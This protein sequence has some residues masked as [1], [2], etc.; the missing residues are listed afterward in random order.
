[1][2]SLRNATQRRNHRE[3]AQPENREK[4]GLLEKHKDYSLRAKDYNE[5]KKR[6]QI[7]RQ[8]ATERNPDEFHYGMLSSRSRDGK[9]IVDRGNPVLSQDAVKLLK[10]QDS[11]YLRTM[12]QRTRRAVE[13]LEQEFVIKEGEG[14]K[15]L[16][17]EVG[18]G[19][20]QHV[21]FVGSRE[22]QSRL[23]PGK[24]LDL[25]SRWDDSG[26]DTTMGKEN[27][28]EDEDEEKDEVQDSA[29]H[30][31][32]IQ[33][34]KRAI[35]KEEAALKK[36]KLLRKQHRKEQDARRSKLAAL[37]AREKD[38]MDAENELELQRAKMSNTVGGATKAGVK[39][40]VRERK[41]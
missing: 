16:G 22:E 39:W 6:L 30:I 24:G 2:S 36:E 4:W 31:Q 10:T 32:T 40:K 13:K 11:G 34:S 7:L 37:Q 29:T 8:K 41:K 20:G 26:R 17:Q 19:E 5:K 33:R 9:K 15:I 25:R 27:E 38:L 12:I 21:I 18:K 28:D 1:M 3:R 23:T 14:V 35:A